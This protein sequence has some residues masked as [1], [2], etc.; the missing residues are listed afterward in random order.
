MGENRQSA[1]I[2]SKL[3]Q[4]LILA[5]AVAVQLGRA[6]A[7][8]PPSPDFATQI[9][10]I[11]SKY[12]FSCHG[13]DEA[14]RKAGLRLDTRAGAIARNE[15]GEV[16]VVPGDPAASQLLE[17]VSTSDKDERMPPKA[18]PGPSAA[19]QGLLRQW[20]AAGAPY[21]EHWAFVAPRRPAKPVVQNGGWVR[22]DLDR[23]VLARLEAQ[24]L[25]PQPEAPPETLIRRLSLDLTGIPPT[26][27]EVDAF[28][29]DRS[30]DA[31]ERVVDRLLASPR[32]GERL[33]T[34]WLDAARYADSHGFQQDDERS[35]W[36]WRDWVIE[37][38]N[39]DMPFDRFTL[40]Q[41]AG[42]LL[43]DAT[44]ETTVAT[45]FHRNHRTSAE[46]G[47]DA[48]EFR[49]E[50]VFDRA[51]TTAT[52]WL[53]LTLN[54]A[55]CHDHKYDPILQKDFYRFAA[56]FDS[57]EESGIRGAERS[58]AP[59]VRLP[60]GAQ[61]ERSAALAAA[62]IG[63]ENALATLKAATPPTEA[64]ALAAGQAALAAAKKARDAFA[65]ESPEVMVLKERPKPR[66]TYVLERGQYGHR[67]ARVEA[68]TPGF[69]PPLPADA[70]ANRLAL[71]RW[72]V[73]P[74][75]P[76]T[77]RVQVNRWWEMLFGTGLVA[78]LENFGGQAEPPSNAGLLDWLAV[79]FREQ[80]WS[81]KR[82]L[83]TM[84]TSATYRQSAAAP[85]ESIARDPANRLL[86][87]G[88]RFRLTPEMIRDQALAA[89]GLLVERFGGPAIRPYEPASSWD[90]GQ[91]GGNLNNYTPATDDGLWRRGVYVVWKRTQPP[92]SMVAF[93]APSREF[94]TVRRL[95]TNTPLQALTTFNDLTTSVAARVLAVRII[96][97]AAT[98]EERLRLAMRHVLGRRPDA[99]ELE[100]LVA[101]LKRRLD[102]YAAD[103]AAAKAVL[104]VGTPAPPPTLAP[105]EL[106]A[107]AQTCALLLNLDETLT[108]E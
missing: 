64:P 32:Y 6:R 51:E 79:E 24:G 16:A 44:P 83:R 65:K 17:R 103:P 34:P 27:A 106:A 8:A 20:I 3:Q 36:R 47:I 72:L 88:P 85:A 77:A 49:I 33:A 53:G 22:G 54:C 66:E 97:E 73:D 45:G 95:R 19:E 67:G 71:A 87:R 7:E 14:K 25:K 52:V 90:G 30:P 102:R 61:A 76:L 101:G 26:L 11:L 62:V 96:G 82:L 48:E 75:N 10:P 18:K 21:A 41:T 42:D 56:Y 5:L 69:L 70:P 89:S 58:T 35:M 37:A 86:A 13:P 38:Y 94:C 2:V 55:R 91:G 107:Y 59:L 63:A 98:P 1:E 93:D 108:R 105:A 31:Y 12:C 78:T 99:S 84:V 23:Q 104:A 80:G 4:T 92:P 100:I 15:D 57:I 28:L 9:R 46:G 68:G 40:L 29:A 43:P 74:A 50:S 39:A 60:T 81:T